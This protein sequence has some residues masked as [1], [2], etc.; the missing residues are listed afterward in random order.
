MFN[1]VIGSM[2]L[3]A[4]LMTVP[5][6][7]GEIDKAATAVSDETEAEVEK[8]VTT[9]LENGILTIRIRETEDV[10]DPDFWW[11]AY[12][13]DKGDASFV[14]LLTQSTDE[15]GLAYAGSFR[16]IDDGDDVIRLVKTNGKY[17]REYLD[18]EVTTEN[19]KITEVTGGGQGF[20]TDAD[21]LAPILEG[22]WDEFEGGNRS[23]EIAQTKDGGLA[24]VISDGSG[25]DG[26]TT[27]YTMTAYYDAVQDNLVYWDGSE[28]T[29]A[30]GTGE[31]VGTVQDETAETG[32]GTGLFALELQ[33]DGS[34]G[35][36]WK[37]DT[38]GNTD[39]NTFFKA[40]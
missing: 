25:R 13:G 4:A 7:A 35:I 28:V 20:A 1:K 32:E 24:F 8:N 19:G 10:Q 17:S 31:E 16:A 27:F 26:M 30:I 38:F 2:I 3:A 9:D 39:V 5:V 14:E 33:E 12:T 18:F 37:D 6:F 21:T 40:S 23:M 36:L 29:V 11:E 34:I 22:V 15:E